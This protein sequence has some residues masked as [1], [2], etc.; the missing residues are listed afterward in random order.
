MIAVNSYGNI[1]VDSVFDSLFLRGLD[2]EVYGSMI[3]KSSDFGVN[4]L[5]F[6][7]E[8]IYNGKK[9]ELVFTN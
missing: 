8:Y 4:V 1:A 6:F 9:L 5:S 2:L 7:K 3:E